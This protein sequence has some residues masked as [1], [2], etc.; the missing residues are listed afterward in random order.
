MNKATVPARVSALVARRR[1]RETLT[2]HLFTRGS[3]TYAR[4]GGRVIRGG[5]RVKGRKM[6]REFFFPLI[7]MH[8]LPVPCFTPRR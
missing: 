2:F 7:F 3:H 6:E 1:N 4:A 8:F 5:M